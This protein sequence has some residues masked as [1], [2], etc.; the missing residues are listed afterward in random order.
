[1]ERMVP[2]RLLLLGGMVT[3]RIFAP[4]VGGG[5]MEEEILVR[6]T[7]THERGGIGARDVVGT[8]MISR[9]ASWWQLW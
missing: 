6:W 9:L 3:G 4:E 5:A 8:V 1:M 7:K 2:Y